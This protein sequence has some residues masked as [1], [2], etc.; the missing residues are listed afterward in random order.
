M[1]IK[2]SYVLISLATYNLAYAASSTNPSIE[3]DLKAS[4]TPPQNIR[5]QDNNCTW[6]NNASLNIQ[7]GESDNDFCH[8][9]DRKIGGIGHKLAA[10]AYNMELPSGIAKPINGKDSDVILE[11]FNTPYRNITKQ[12][13]KEYAKLGYNTIWISPPQKNA[14]VQYWKKTIPAWYGAY[15][16][17]DFGQIGDKHNVMSFAS[18]NELADLV[19]RTHKLGLK[20]VVDLAIHQFAQPGVN[21][22]HFYTE[23]AGQ[24]YNFE[25][26]NMSAIQT[27]W[28]PQT[29]VAGYIPFNEQQQCTADTSHDTATTVALVGNNPN[30]KTFSKNIAESA[31]W[32]DDFS[33]LNGW[34]DGVLPAASNSSL[35]V[36]K[37]SCRTHQVFDGFAAWLMGANYTSGNMTS[38]ATAMAGFNVDGFRIDD[39]S[40]QSVEFYNQ[41]FKATVAYNKDSNLF[42]GEYPTQSAN[43]Y[44]KYIAI[45]TIKGNDNNNHQMKMLNFPLLVTLK[46]AFN[47]NQL[48]T[49]LQKTIDARYAYNESGSLTGNEAINLVID[50]DTAPDS[51]SSRAM[52]PWDGTPQ[53]PDY[54]M[55]YYTAPLAY[56]VILAMQAG[57]PYV[58][59]DLQAANKVGISEKGKFVSEVANGSVSYWNQN[60]V[61]AGV[62]F[63]NQTLGQAMRWGQVNNASNDGVASFTRGDNYLFILNNSQTG[64]SANNSATTLKDGEYIDLMSHQIITVKNHKL[65][66]VFIPQKAVM[67]FVPLQGK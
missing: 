1:R 36:T 15:Q 43:D 67:Y 23:Y 58:F 7:A 61:I 64:Y 38:K 57:T 22:T 25:S 44:T 45:N 13:L 2:L 21:N 46:Q 33:G 10:N 34:F 54:V 26:G 65:A 40:G 8:G 16:P 24:K 5:C 39:I 60:E 12:M 55:N 50:Q 56:G 3:L 63:H 35:G 4:S 28:W 30:G 11:L 41:L 52:C 62:Y 42:F 51:I 37:I 29:K 48:Q 18:A 27:M 17:L 59:A 14:Y 47:S 53:K 19:N 49:T 31:A 6:S 66:T 20:I 9:T 32:Q